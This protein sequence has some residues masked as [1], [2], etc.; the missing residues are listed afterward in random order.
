MDAID[1]EWARFQ[2]V[3]RWRAAG[4]C[5]R[6]GAGKAHPLMVYCEPCGAQSMAQLRAGRTFQCCPTCGHWGLN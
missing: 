5:V 2:Q 4:L 1:V 6:C 3:E